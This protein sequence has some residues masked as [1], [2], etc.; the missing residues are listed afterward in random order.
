MVWDATKS[1]GDLITSGDWNDMVADQKG[2]ASR[3]KD[4]GSDEIDAAE[5]AGGLGTSGQVLQ[6]DGSSATWSTFSS[7]A[8]VSDDGTQV[9]ASPDDVNYGSNLAVTDDGDGS[10]T[11]DASGGGGSTQTVDGDK[12]LQ[13]VIR[14]GAEGSSTTSTSFVTIEESDIALDFSDLTDGNGNVYV[15]LEAHLENNLDIINFSGVQKDF[16]VARQLVYVES[17]KEF[18][19]IQANEDNN[20]E[21]Q[22]QRID[23][24]FS[25][26]GTFTIPGDFDN[27]VGATYRPG[28]DLVYVLLDN[29][30]IVEINSDGT[31]KQQF[32]AIFE[33]NEITGLTWDENDSEFYVWEYDSTG[34]IIAY[35][36]SFNRVGVEF[37]TTIG[38]SAVP[39]NPFEIAVDPKTDSLFVG[40]Q[41]QFIEQ[42]D[43]S[44]GNLLEEQNSGSGSR[45]HGLTVGFG[46]NLYAVEQASS[47][48]AVFGG[49]TVCNIQ[50]Q[51]AGTNVSN[52]EA[53]ARPDRGKDFGFAETGWIDLSTESGKESYQLGLK[54]TG[55]N[56]EGSFNSALLKVATG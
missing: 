31:F 47:E 56:N 5:L 45:I 42:Y 28:E 15:K 53:R 37:S 3:H 38:A 30:N 8:S 12:T 27:S 6:T 51:N 22:I 2:H 46:D 16:N 43:L 18:W 17:Q 24:S 19:E 39:Y 44:S 54:V 4:G 11:I 34:D 9:L 40:F 10:V 35:D 25:A 14:F 1:P 48:F 13:Q 52:S 41:G 20:G 33:S 49:N 36:S 32:V 21:M 26:I 7:G 55:S 23:T 29:D 50:R